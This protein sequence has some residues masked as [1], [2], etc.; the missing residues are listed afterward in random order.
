[1]DR[2]FSSASSINISVLLASLRLEGSLHMEQEQRVSDVLG[3]ADDRFVLQHVSVLSLDGSRIESCPELLVDKRQVLAVVPRESAGYLA[4]RRV[5][6]MGLT[7]PGNSASLALA[8]MLPPF[9]VQGTFHSQ[10]PLNLEHINARLTRF[11]AL[12]N[13]DVNLGRALLEEKVTLLV[14]RD[15]MAAIGPM[16]NEA[17]QRKTT[18]PTAMQTAVQSLVSRLAA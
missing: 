5:A 11:F 1:M 4:S 14:N 18:E 3:T 8:V 16:E 9:H 6:R 13:A 17:L 7:T 15:L 2:S 10:G 12:T